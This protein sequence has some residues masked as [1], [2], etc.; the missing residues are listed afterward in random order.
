MKQSAL[1]FSLIL[2][3]SCFATSTMAMGTLAGKTIS[4][5][6]YVD[7]GDANRNNQTRGHSNI[8]TMTVAQIASIRINPASSNKTGANS[9]DVTFL[10]E[11]HN[12]GNA[13]DTFDFVYANTT[14]WKPFRIKFYSDTNGNHRY[15]AGVDALMSPVVNQTY[16]TGLVTPDADFHVLMVVT[17]PTSMIT[18][19]DQSISTI[20]IT[21]HS[22]FNPAAASTANFTVK[23]PPQ[24]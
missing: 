1:L 7:Y 21:A 6:T 18:A 9:T 16:K 12:A 2:L 11:I 4:N 13:S 24:S 10:V 15:D 5:Q 23:S 20:R 19:A 17:I 8:V 3:V 22:V 14:G